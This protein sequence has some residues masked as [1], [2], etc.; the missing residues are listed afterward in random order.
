[1][2][3]PLFFVGNLCWSYLVV[4]G[5]ITKQNKKNCWCCFWCRR[6]HCCSC[7][8]RHSGNCCWSC[9]DSFYYFIFIV[10]VIDDTFIVAVLTP[11]LLSLVLLLLL[12]PLLLLLLLPLLTSHPRI[13]SKNYQQNLIIVF[14][15]QTFW[16]NS[17]FFCRSFWRS[18]EFFVEKVTWEHFSLWHLAKDDERQKLS[19][20]EAISGWFDFK[21]WIFCQMALLDPIL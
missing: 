5:A 15:P 8:Q 1:M 11:E 3:K 4:L 21:S 6:H 10:V 16:W 18:N 17:V 9:C 20:R 19:S 2:A 14:S 12:S 13:M 7:S